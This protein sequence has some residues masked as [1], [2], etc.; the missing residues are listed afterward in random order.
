MSSQDPHQEPAVPSPASEVK[1]QLPV[2]RSLREPLSIAKIQTW[3]YD[4]EIRRSTIGVSPKWLVEFANNYLSTISELSELMDV[5]QELG[6]SFTGMRHLLDQG[7]DVFEVHALYSARHELE[8]NRHEG[9]G[10]WLPSMTLMARFAKALNHVPVTEGLADDVMEAFEAVQR[11]RPKIMKCGLA[12][13][14]VCEI[15]EQ[16]H[17]ETIDGVIAELEN[18]SRIPREEH[19][20]REME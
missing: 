11:C 7:F 13:R 20:P 15:A 17:I 6:G 19:D 5:R 16:F 4:N 3:L 8:E 2:L 9:A 18:Q 10:E 1:P 12:L 14:L